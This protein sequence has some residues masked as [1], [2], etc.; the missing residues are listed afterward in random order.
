[1][2][3]N[4]PVYYWDA[5]VYLAWLKKEAS[6]HLA[7][8]EAIAH[9][10]KRRNNIIV[11][12]VITKL[13]VLDASLTIDQ[14]RLFNESFSFGT[15]ELYELDG[16]VVLKARAYRSYYFKNRI[17]GRCLALP[18]AIHLATAKACQ[19][20]EFHTFDD[21]GKGGISLLSLSGNVAGDDIKICPPFVSSTGNLF[22]V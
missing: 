20:E 21:G 2:S 16:A 19:S 15:H 4:K 6:Q 22:S 9:E 11:T 5:C 14:E 3:G 18:D 13:E 17:D 1:M 12:S 10:N 7:S 8:I